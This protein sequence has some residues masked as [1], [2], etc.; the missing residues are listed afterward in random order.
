[1]EVAKMQ[2]S[3]V[4]MIKNLK[5][6]RS[7]MPASVLLAGQEE[8]EE[9]PASEPRSSI[10]S[11]AGTDRSGLGKS[12]V[13][14]R[15]S[16]AGDHRLSMSSRGSVQQGSRMSM[17]T[18]KQSMATKRTN[19]TRK[20]AETKALAVAAS[21]ALQVGV[22]KKVS[23]FMSCNIRNFSEIFKA[24][25]DS[26]SLHGEYLSKLVECVRL[27]KGLPDYF[28]G[29]RFYATFN[30]ARATP[31]FK[32]ASGRCALACHEAVTP[33]FA[34]ARLKYPDSQ[35]GQAS[36]A[37][38]SGET[39]A[40]N[41]GNDMMKKYCMIGLAPSLTHCLE[42]HNAFMQTN[43]MIDMRVKKDLEQSHRLR[44]MLP[45]D[46]KRTVQRTFEVV[47]VA[48]ATEDE[49]MYQLEEAHAA[50]P[51]KIISTA[52][53]MFAKGA[54]QDAVEKLKSDK[55]QTAQHAIMME[56]IQ[57]KME[58]YPSALD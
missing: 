14:A 41:I 57:A 53:D 16:D 55:D 34:Q 2:G 51:G 5:E 6:F 40:G 49:W 46:Y 47:E 50:D 35:G 24:E 26:S 43:V 28:T 54:Y 23:A 44:Q 36:T 7:Y 38:A 4:S 9:V 33:I 27:S 52:V 11:S 39:I 15:A 31:G 3:F 13:Y 45:I 19:H 32:A 12:A 20:S 8:E 48:K 56:Y 42:Q 1:M 58:P 18:D 17:A 30:G 25:K 21:A 22:Q 10:V 37:A 29:D